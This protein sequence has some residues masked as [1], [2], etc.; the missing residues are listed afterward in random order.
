MYRQADHKGSKPRHTVSSISGSSA[1]EDICAATSEWQCRILTWLNRCLIGR[2]SIVPRIV[3]ELG[4]LHKDA[5]A[6]RGAITSG[7]AIASGGVISSSVDVVVIVAAARASR[8][9]VCKGHG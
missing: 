5:I 8:I 3:G 6:S 7:A 1:S 2:C 9:V 4:R